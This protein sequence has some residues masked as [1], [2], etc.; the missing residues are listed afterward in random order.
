M[1]PDSEIHGQDFTATPP[2]VFGVGNSAKWTKFLNSAHVGHFIYHFIIVYII[3]QITNS[4]YDIFA[5]A[6]LCSFLF[7]FSGGA[8]Y[9]I[10]ALGFCWTHRKF[11][12]FL[13]IAIP[14]CSIISFFALPSASI[15]GLLLLISPIH[16]FGITFLRDQKI[17]GGEVPI[18]SFY[19]VSGTLAGYGCAAYAYEIGFLILL[20]VMPPVMAALA[21]REDDL[22]F[23]QDPLRTRKA[24]TC[25]DFSTFALATINTSV[26]NIA[27]VLGTAPSSC[28]AFTIIALSI[29]GLFALGWQYV[30]A[31]CEHY[32]VNRISLGCIAVASVI[33]IFRNYFTFL[34]MQSLGYM[35]FFLTTAGYTAI[36]RMGK[37][38]IITDKRLNFLFGF[39]YQSI[40][41]LILFFSLYSGILFRVG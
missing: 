38:T 2:H 12:T 3:F 24:R 7:L 31:H 18:H 19:G 17:E 29:F 14:S 13:G 22:I 27:L 26:M 10:S 15:L 28:S 35:L 41:A 33:C 36:N 5:I 32:W 39:S 30:E 6:V 40:S 1:I 8:N 23:W 11:W 25:P 20:M 34:N 16:S 21:S 37:S 9:T 4:G